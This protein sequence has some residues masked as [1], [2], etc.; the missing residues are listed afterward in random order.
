[1]L[2]YTHKILDWKGT[3]G[4]RMTP[5]I[6][7]W[8]YAILLCSHNSISSELW[9]IFLEVLVTLI[10]VFFC[11]KCCFISWFKDKIHSITNDHK[12]PFFLDRRPFFVEYLRTTKL[13]DHRT[14]SVRPRGQ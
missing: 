1:M 7:M 2:L 9:L 14:T 3:Q 5:L 4:I 11:I 8:I 13:E 12:V 10:Q 6:Q